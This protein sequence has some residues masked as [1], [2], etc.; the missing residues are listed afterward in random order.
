MATAF[1]SSS[2]LV[3]EQRHRSHATRCTTCSQ[4]ALPCPALV[5]VTPNGSCRDTPALCDL[6]V[7]AMGTGGAT[8]VQLRDRIASDRA[9]GDAAAAL[10]DA[11][12]DPRAL[13]IN[14]PGVVGIEIARAVGRGV[15]VHLRECDTTR[16]LHLMAGENVV[17]GCSVHSAEAARRAMGEVPNVRPSYVQVGT[18]FETGSHPGQVPDGPALLDEVRA[19]VGRN[20]AI[21]GVGGITVDNVGLLVPM[22]DGVAVISGIA[23]V[24]GPA[25]ASRRLMKAITDASRR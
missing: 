16:M 4:R 23:A 1:S 15:G 21:L 10:A 19:A 17:V 22:A 24:E 20:V 9:L 2:A 7:A 13:V 11:L 6:A 25:L 3:Q 18:M 8:L 12:P 14:G 5:F